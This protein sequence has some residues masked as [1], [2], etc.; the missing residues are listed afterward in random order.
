MQFKALEE[1]LGYVFKNQK[2]LELA[3]IH[4]SSNNIS[5]NERL[6]F[7]GDTILNTIISEYLFVKF[8]NEKEGLL[9]RMRSH[10]VKGETL[11]KKAIEIDIIKF[12]KLSK[13]TAL[14]S[15]T[16]KHSILEGSV[17]SI[18]GAVFL[19]S[20]WDSV[21]NFILKL[22]SKELSI[23]EADQEFRDSKTELQEL[24]QSKKLKLPIYITSESNSGF[25]CRLELPEG[26]FEASG[27]SKRQAEIAAAKEA[28]SHLKKNNA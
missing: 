20:N 28:L 11:S 22:F 24:L 27:N 9:T 10:L 26:L 16:R 15:E 23:I 14:L 12:I 4:K 3:L 19:D 7:L 5:N 6:E 17:E 2:L 18:I 8:P 1:K 25:D 13:G 21:D